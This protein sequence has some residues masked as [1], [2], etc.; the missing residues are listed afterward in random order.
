M[1]KLETIVV[2]QKKYSNRN[3]LDALAS[4]MVLGIGLML[5]EPYVRPH[6]KTMAVWVQSRVAT[7]DLNTEIQNIIR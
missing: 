3:M 5:A 6:L 1:Y 7:W 4:G 2:D